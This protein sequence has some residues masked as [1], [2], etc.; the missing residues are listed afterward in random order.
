MTQ[1]ICRDL[2]GPD[3]IRSLAEENDDREVELSFSSESPVRGESGIEI[4]YHSPG[5]V[6]LS[7]LMRSGCVLFSHDLMHPVAAI[8]SASIEQRRGVARIRFAHTA[9]GDEALQLVK[10]GVIRGVSVGAAV[11]RWEKLRRGQTSA[12]GRFR[13]PGNVARSWYPWEISLVTAP[14]DATVGI[15]R[16]GV[17]GSSIVL[18]REMCRNIYIANKNFVE[19]GGGEQKK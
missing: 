13:G 17:P 12:D 8:V 6:D 16:S 9:A 19:F 5:A 14:G 7:Y 1:M 11:K 18:G 2:F 15:N 4:L 10:D 3:I